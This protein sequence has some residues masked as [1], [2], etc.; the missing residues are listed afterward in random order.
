M[1]L[2]PVYS[3]LGFAAKLASV[4]DPSEEYY[5]STLSSDV[6]LAFTGGTLFKP[7]PLEPGKLGFNTGLDLFLSDTPVKASEVSEPS[8][9]IGALF[10]QGIGSGI[11]AI[12]NFFKINLGINYT[13]EF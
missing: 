2:G 5:F 6:T 8:G 7:I 11:N 12:R 4:H 10:A 13:V 1:E 3:G 9:L